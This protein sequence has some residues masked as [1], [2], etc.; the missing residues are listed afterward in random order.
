MLAVAGLEPT[1]SLDREQ[2]TQTTTPTRPL[3]SYWLKNIT[4]EGIDNNFS[5]LQFC[6]CGEFKGSK[7]PTQN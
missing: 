7:F 2:S 6:G 3:N 1:T 5:G 4:E